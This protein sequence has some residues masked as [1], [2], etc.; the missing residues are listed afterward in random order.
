MLLH[1][2]LKTHQG[3]GPS[4]ST[5]RM[6][7]QPSMKLCGPDENYRNA[8]RVVAVAVL[9]NS[10]ASYRM[11]FWWSPVLDHKRKKVK[12]VFICETRSSNHWFTDDGWDTIRVLAMLP[13]DGWCVSERMLIS[14][15]SLSE[16]PLGK[17]LALGP[18]ER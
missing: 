10:V 16:E 13:K 2:I 11:L 17:S 3:G 15:L 5:H 14:I 8:S 4:H 12:T 1:N 6:T 18:L 9:S 7:C